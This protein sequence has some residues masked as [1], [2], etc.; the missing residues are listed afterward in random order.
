MQEYGH[1]VVA[2]QLFDGNESFD[3][4]MATIEAVTGQ[5]FVAFVRGIMPRTIS[6]VVMQVGGQG[7]RHL[8]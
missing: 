1:H 5:D 6:E 4:V 7:D 3:A 2:K 8:K